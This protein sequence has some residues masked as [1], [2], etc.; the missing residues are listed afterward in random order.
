MVGILTRLELGTSQ[1][2]VRKVTTTANM[3][4]DIDNA[5]KFWGYSLWQRGAEQSE[6]DIENRCDHGFTN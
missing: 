5:T 2:H 4:S 3:L 1:I 6:W